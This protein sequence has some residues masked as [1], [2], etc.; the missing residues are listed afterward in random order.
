LAGTL[1]RGI[2]VGHGETQI[3]RARKGAIILI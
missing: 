3:R 1:A 2:C